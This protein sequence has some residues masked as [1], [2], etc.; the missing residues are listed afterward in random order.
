[1]YRVFGIPTYCKNSE[2]LTR[3]IN[4]LFI[5][6]CIFS[7]TQSHIWRIVALQASLAHTLPLVSLC[8]SFFSQLYSFFLLKCILEL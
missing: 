1:M 6:V 4:A 7:R 5:G 3:T 8:M 2:G